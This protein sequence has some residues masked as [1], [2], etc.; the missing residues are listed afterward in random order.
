ML[1]R[2]EY[3]ETNMVIDVLDVV[4]GGEVYVTSVEFDNDYQTVRTG[5]TID[6]SH[7][8]NGGGSTPDNTNVIYISSDPD[9][10]TTSGLVG[11]SGTTTFTVRAEDTTNGTIEGTMTVNVNNG[12]KVG[13]IRRSRL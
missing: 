5:Q 10:V 4:E 7:T 3:N 2:S 12:V 6:L 13:R 8:F 1:F 11:N 9:I